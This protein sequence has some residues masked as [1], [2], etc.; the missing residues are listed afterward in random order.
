[1]HHLSVRKNEIQGVSDRRFQRII[2]VIRD[3]MTTQD[4]DGGSGAIADRL[5]IFF[6]GD[7]ARAL[8]VARTE[9]GSAANAAAKDGYRA[10]GADAKSWL[11]VPP[12]GRNRPEHL[13]MD[14][15]TV[16]IDQV[17]SNGLS[18]PGDPQGDAEEICNC[19]CTLLPEF[20]NA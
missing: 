2:D 14:G 20:I 13:A 17:F 5:K 12:D 9:A 11:P 6:E 19:R 18:F 7:D 15:E 1:L 8:L 10:G 16:P 4:Y 3:A